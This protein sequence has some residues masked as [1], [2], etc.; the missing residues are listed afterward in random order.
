MRLIAKI[1]IKGKFLT[2]TGLHIGGNTSSLEIGG[3]DLNVVKTGAGVPYIPGS[4]LKGK[5]LSL[6]AKVRGK[7]EKKED[8]MEMK[9]LFGDSGGREN[10]TATRLQV[11]DAMLDRKHFES[12]AGFGEK[13]ER[14]LDFDYSEI[15]TEN[16]IDRS[17]GSAKHPRHIERVPAGAI[18]DFE[19]VLD[20]YE[21]DDARK[22]LNLID[23]ALQLLELDYLGGHGTRGS[24]KV[25]ILNLEIN[26]KEISERGIKTMDDQPWNDIFD[27][28]LN[29]IDS[30][31]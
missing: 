30:R 1:I 4:S 26:G 7:M 28:Y 15:K 6:L 19:L 3:V 10:K 13:S 31:Q 16:T 27:D 12:D 8:T 17:T 21:E 2:K 25:E 23:E 14:A 22:F 11:R 29:K 24:G 9:L 20:I 18:F 5:L